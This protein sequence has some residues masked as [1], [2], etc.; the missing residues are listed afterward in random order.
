MCL[1]RQVKA[2]AWAAHACSWL[3]RVQLSLEASEV[4]QDTSKYDSNLS[5]GYF[6]GQSSEQRATSYSFQATTVSHPVS[7]EQGC[8]GHPAVHTHP[9]MSREEG[10]DILT[11]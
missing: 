6:L 8:A 10:T 1:Q 9:L 7:S 4:V 11:M 3:E 5:R 2:C